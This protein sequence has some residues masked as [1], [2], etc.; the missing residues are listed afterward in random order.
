MRYLRHFSLGWKHSRS[1]KTDSRRWAKASSCRVGLLPP[2]CNVTI[3]RCQSALSSFWKVSM[4]Q[5]RR[6][7]GEGDENCDYYL[8]L[9]LWMRDVTWLLFHPYTILNR[10]AV[11]IFIHLHLKYSAFFLWRSCRWQLF[12][13]ECIRQ[14]RAARHPLVR[15]ETAEGRKR[16][17]RKLQKCRAV[18][19]SRLVPPYLASLW[20]WTEIDCSSPGRMRKMSFRTTSVFC[21][22]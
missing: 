12:L 15:V 8:V 18:L 14:D 10:A 1:W 21:A 7:L 2:H 19:K 4:P 5:R 17:A 3:N 11:T 6:Q 20:S 16:N 13:S 22:G 9:Y